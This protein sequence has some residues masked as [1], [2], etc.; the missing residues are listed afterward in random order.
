MV[1]NA[2]AKATHQVWWISC[3]LPRPPVIPHFLRHPVSALMSLPERWF[4]P[5]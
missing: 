1:I 3:R 5:A 2:D 4:E